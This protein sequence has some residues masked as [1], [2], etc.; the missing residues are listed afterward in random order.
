MAPRAGAVKKKERRDGRGQVDQP[1]AVPICWLTHRG[2]NTVRML[3]EKMVFA[4][5]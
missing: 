2:K 4:K 5:S 1:G 3:T